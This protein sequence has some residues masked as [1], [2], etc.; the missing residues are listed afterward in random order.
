MPMYSS[1]QKSAG[2]SIIAVSAVLNLVERCETRVNLAQGGESCPDKEVR[3]C[4]KH[5]TAK[6]IIPLGEL[7]TQPA[8]D[9][10]QQTLR[11]L[12]CV[13]ARQIVLF[14]GKEADDGGYHRHR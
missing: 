5:P 14:S 2:S 8:A 12:G 11:I 9:R 1:L 7:W 3:L 10:R 13:V 6:E 4:T